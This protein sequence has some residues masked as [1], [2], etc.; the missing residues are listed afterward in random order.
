MQQIRRI[1][2]PENKRPWRI[3]K[4]ES[5]EPEKLPLSPSSSIPLTRKP[6]DSGYKIASWVIPLNQMYPFH[7]QDEDGCFPNNF[8]QERVHSLL[9]DPVIQKVDNTTPIDRSLSSWYRKF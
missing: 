1:Q 9:F 7:G 5:L 8:S 6:E 2:L 4:E 3:Q